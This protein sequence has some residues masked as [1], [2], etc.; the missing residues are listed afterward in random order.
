[1]PPELG[2]GEGERPQR[3]TFIVRLWRERADPADTG[4]RGSV[5]FVQGGERRSARDMAGA[6]ALVE[7]WLERLVE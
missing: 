5:E 3:A 6:L 7:M 1:V 2:P 4:W